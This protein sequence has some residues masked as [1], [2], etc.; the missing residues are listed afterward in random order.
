MSR[1]YLYNPVVRQ[2]I[3]F[4]CSPESKRVL[5][6]FIAPRIFVGY[7]ATQAFASSV[8]PLLKRRRAFIVTDP[9][10]KA[11]ALSVEKILQSLNFTTK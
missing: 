6:T 5:S 7:A 4:M 2:T 8:A 10:I 1:W 3:Q 11:L 9:H